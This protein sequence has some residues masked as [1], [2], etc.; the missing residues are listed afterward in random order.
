[1]QIRKMRLSRFVCVLLSTSIIISLLSACGNDYVTQSAYRKVNDSILETKVIATNTDYKL[2]WDKD[3]KAVVL[4]NSEDDIIMS[5]ILYKNFLEGSSSANGNSAISIT[6]F[7]TK[8]LKTETLR[9][10]SLF[11]D[12]G[13]MICKEIENGIRVSY[14]FNNYK[15][16]IPVDYVLR[17]DS[18]EVTVDSS[19]I[20]E[21]GTNYRLVSI[22]LVPFMCST[23]NNAKN[24][25]IFVP[26][27]CG[28][29]MYS[30]ETVDGVKQYSGEVYGVDAARQLVDSYTD[31]TAIRMPVFGASGGNKAIFA[32]IEDGAGAAHIDA[33]S[34]NDALGYSNAYATFYVRGYDVFSND[35]YALKG[36]GDYSTRFSDNI[37]G[38]TFKIGFYPLFGEDASYNGMARR[39]RQYLVDNDLFYKSDSNSVPYSVT[40][41]GGT[42][43]MKSFFGL[44]YKKVVP[45]TTFSH[46]K[47]IIEELKQ[48]VGI[49]PTVRMQGYGDNG[50]RPGT[51][52]GGNN[53]LSVYGDKSNVKDLN[54]LFENEKANL[55]FDSEIVYFSN[56][57][58]GF[59]K[60]SDTAKT[61]I[62]K[63]IVQYPLSPTRLT[64]S[65]NGFNVLS[66]VRL[67]DA[68]QKVIDKTKSYDGSGISLSTLGSVA[69]S[70][71]ESLEYDNKNKIESDVTELLNK[72]KNNGY[73]VAVAA[74]NS[75]AACASDD[76]FDIVTNNGNNLNLDVSIPF[77]QMVFHSFKPMYSEAVNLSE[78]IDRA[79]TEAIAFGMGIGFTLTAEYVSESIDLDEY[80]LYGTVYDDNRDY[81]SKYL[82][83]NE[84]INVYTQIA[85]SVF[86]EY[87]LL[88]NG[89]SVSTYANGLKIYTNHTAEKANCPAGAIEAYSY[90]VEGMD[91]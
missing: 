76:L 23:A 46:A 50:I 87:L 14:F 54:L 78:D 38:R 47:A 70:D 86:E 7:N 63:R 30:T 56:S 67:G 6:V 24:S 81:F 32:I 13:N 90:I 64:D 57:G 43:I 49:I 77:Y 75:Y 53:Y 68:V 10:Y 17:E 3:A 52:A 27:G 82:I 42:S 59:S 29:L 31:G 15:I 18:V 48:N 80:R 55:F 61:A 74:A 33:Q 22:S 71:Y 2:C 35:S 69:Y 12:D 79:V 44:P 91:R 40:I 16:A 84:Y 60:N 65:N 66:R 89:V 41:L 72:V 9:S 25:Y 45:L 1:M 8:T 5:D 62:L 83:D 88:G 58:F 11:N 20:I 37:S 19:K 36:K 26:S 51:V 21:E 28:A 39:Y 34:G 85:D 4:K 73:K